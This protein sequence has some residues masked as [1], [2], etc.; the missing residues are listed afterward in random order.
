MVQNI[1]KHKSYNWK[2][3]DQYQQYRDYEL[4][5]GVSVS[6]LQQKLLEIFLYFKQTCE[7]NGLTYWCGGGTM[8]GAVRHKG[9][10]PWDDDLDVFMPREDYEKLYQIWN[11]VADTSKYI[12]VRT[13]ETHNYH[14]TAMNLVD[15]STTYINRHSENED[16]YH[17]CYIDIIPFEGCPDSKFGRALQIYHSIMYG[18]FNAQ[19]LPDNQGKLLKLPVK[20]LLGLFRNPK[21]RYKIW[22]YHEKRMTKFNFKSSRYVKETVSS[23]R[24]LFWLQNRSSFDT[25]DAEFEGVTVK[26]PAGYDHYMKQIYGDYMS[27]PK[28]LSIDIASRYGVIKYIN[29]KEP[30]TKFRGIYYLSDK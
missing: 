21:M 28:N 4:S 20:I 18:I 23:F 8:L 10:I 9:F 1:P 22:K 14:H 26:I 27:M 6:Q 5:P 24:A 15:I 2:I 7:E 16:I 3:M 11:K 19:R 29:L 30:Y 25:I 17:G 13:D 12:L